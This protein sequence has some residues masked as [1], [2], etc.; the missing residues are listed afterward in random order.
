M[1]LAL[2]WRWYVAPIGVAFAVA[3]IYH[4]QG[5][6]FFPLLQFTL[7]LTCATSFVLFCG[8]WFTSSGWFLE[9]PHDD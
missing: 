9:E 8:Q 7:V 1:K 5:V 4:E 3:W 2:E 6:D